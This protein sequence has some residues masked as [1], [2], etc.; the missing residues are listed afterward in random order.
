M[1]MTIFLFLSSNSHFRICRC[2][3]GFLYS[4]NKAVK[5]LPAPHHIQR[6]NIKPAMTVFLGDCAFFN[7]LRL[8]F[9]IKMKN[10]NFYFD[11]I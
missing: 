3:S 7:L 4:A 11:S 9:L 8:V 6:T 10:S 5:Q 2:F 1:V